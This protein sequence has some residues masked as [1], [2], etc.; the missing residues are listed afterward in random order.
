M[1][2]D[3]LALLLLAL[4]PLAVR[5]RGVDKYHRHNRVSAR[6]GVLVVVVVGV[7]GGAVAAVAVVVGEIDGTVV[8]AVVVVEVEEKAA[9]AVEAEDED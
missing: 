7:E 4:L 1:V 5:R 9:V 2:W 3:R 8:A 6:A